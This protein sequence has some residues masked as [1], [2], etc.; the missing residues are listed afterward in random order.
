M[1]WNLPSYMSHRWNK[2][3]VPTL[4][5]LRLWQNIK[6]NTDQHN[7]Q[8]PTYTCI[9]KPLPNS[10]IT[11]REEKSLYKEVSKQ[12]TAN[13]LQLWHEVSQQLYKTLKTSL[14]PEMQDSK[15]R[16]SHTLVNK[17]DDRTLHFRKKLDKLQNGSKINTPGDKTIRIWFFSTY[18]FTRMMD[19]GYKIKQ[20]SGTNS[21]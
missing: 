21:P 14:Q 11:G 7:K 4:K 13:P 5:H 17:T 18:V 3:I 16:V 20:S 2:D 10:S 6:Y 15:K 19:N 9:T 8:W 1:G 12:V